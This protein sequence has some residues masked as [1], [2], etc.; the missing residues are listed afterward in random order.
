MVPGALK[1]KILLKKKALQKKGKRNGSGKEKTAT[2][3]PS[4]TAAKKIKSSIGTDA[5]TY[6]VSASQLNWKPVQIPDTLDDFEGFYGLEEIDNVDVKIVK[7]KVQ[8]I[9]KDE[10]KTLTEE[11]AELRENAVPEGDFEVE[12]DPTEIAQESEEEEVEAEEEEVEAEEVAD[13]EDENEKEGAEEEQEEQQTVTSDAT[14]DVDVVTP[15]KE[16]AKKPKSKTTTVTTL[17]ESKEE[18]NEIDIPELPSSAS[19]QVPTADQTQTATETSISKSKGKIAASSTSDENELKENTFAQASNIE[20]PTDEVDL[21]EWTEMN[22]SASTLNG[23]HTLGFVK[24]TEIQTRTIPVSISGK[25]VIGKAITG[26]GKTLAYGIPIMERALAEEENTKKLPEEYR[27]HPTA[28]IF[29]PTRELAT[30][31][32]RH[33][34]E[35]FKYS[36]FSDK[37]IMSLTGGLSIQKQERLLSYGPKVLVATPGRCL[38]L[39]EKSTELAQQF[40]SIDILV[41][42]EAD[43]MLQDGQFDEMKKILEILNNYRPKDI[44]NFTKRWQSLIFSATFSKDLFG[45]LVSDHKPNQTKR[46]HGEDADAAEMREVLDILGKKL[47]FRGKP[48]FI[49]VNPTEVVANRI[50]EAMIPCAPMERDLMLYYFISMFPGT[51][52]VFTNS[53]DS[54]KRLAPTLNNLGIPTVSIHSSMMQKQRLRALER[55]TKNSEIAKRE[56]KSSV[57]IA[58]DVAA[59]G[60]DIDDIQH[61]IHYHLPRTADS[62]VHRS[63]RTARAGK[64]G[65]SVVLCSP[66]EASGPLRKLR[67]VIAKKEDIAD[68]KPIT[69]DTDILD[70][71]K[72]RLD[73]AAKIAQAEV[74]SQ[75]VK[76]E[77]SWLEKAAEDLGVDDIDDFEDDFLKRDRKRREGKQLDKNNVK[78][79]KAQLR[80]ALK[81]PIRKSGRRSYIAG[82]LNNIAELLMN[83]QGSDS[84]MGYLQQDALKFLKDKKNKKVRY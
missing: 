73:L 23:L 40:A 12:L 34:K 4:P 51:T 60:L 6:A 48:E 53:I 22:L 74:A 64:E 43:R 14:V 31:V 7:G 58:S 17:M 3:V 38:E 36:P 79:M 55:F 66:Q 65:V 35:L 77:N 37:T 82:G 32:V 75:S 39:L 30:Q 10:K 47:R 52:L 63:G 84:I 44:A 1:Q 61:V 27:K 46:K 5:K 25:D 9:T 54:V 20:L 19:V 13:E 41:L 57:L 76:K 11:E 56:K 26:S 28:I 72:E 78:Y 16:K 21:P 33:L 68:L 83:N 59:R 8:F 15:I 24:P 81:T 49:D 62:Y 2:L 67:R 29:T 71:L 18:N 80:D 50:T 45:K 70:Q 69:I 42:D